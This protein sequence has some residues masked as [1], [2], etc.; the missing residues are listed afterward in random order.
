MEPLTYQQILAEQYEESAR[1]LLVYGETTFEGVEDDGHDIDSYN[2][3]D[4]VGFELPDPHEFQKFQGNRNEAELLPEPK[5]FEDRG[6]QS[7]RYHKDVQ[8]NI[9]SIDTRFRAYAVP[10]ILDAPKTL[11][12]NTDNSLSIQNVISLISSLTSNF[13]FHFGKQIKN[14]M[15]AELTSFEMYNTFF[16]LTDVRNN[17]YIYIKSGAF[18]ENEDNN[19]YVNKTLHPDS[20]Y[21]R[22]PVFITDTTKSTKTLT[23]ELG[24]LGSNGYYYSNTS[25][26]QA[27]NTSLKSAGFTDLSV[28]YVNG[29][30]QFNNVSTTTTY[31]LNFSPETT[32]PNDIV[33]SAI[34]DKLGKLLGFNNYIYEVNPIS[35]SP[36]PP[37]PCDFECGQISACQCYGTLISEDPINMNA[38][39]YIYLQVSDWDN[40][41][42]ETVDHTHFSIFA[43]IPITV[44]KGELIHDIMYNNSVTKKYF[45][46]QPSNLQVIEIEMLDK[47]GKTLL[48]PNTDWS[49]VLEIEEILSHSLY[50]KLREL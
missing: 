17:Y 14:A 27:L 49:M 2:A 31:T 10:G 33:N 44:K 21:T 30:C 8:N 15:T 16:N 12:G 13:I 4:N 9:C 32:E 35:T 28:S 39:S 48:M 25:I 11:I 29:Y 42:H 41:I 5:P 40:I 18:D 1:N 24:P 19:I 20:V 7:V 50:E 36:P 38:D 46:K 23:Q 47:T 22:I 26:I 45:F 43:R 3:K 37:S 34:F 6:K